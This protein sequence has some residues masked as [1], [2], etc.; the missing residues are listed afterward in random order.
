MRGQFLRDVART[1]TKPI[2]RIDLL[3]LDVTF[4]GARSPRLGVGVAS[5]DY[6]PF[7]AAQQA[8]QAAGGYPDHPAAYTLIVVAFAPGSMRN[9]EGKMAAREIFQHVNTDTFLNIGLIED[10]KLPAGTIRVSVLLG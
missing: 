1:V 5:G 3:D 7:R 10:E 4:R 9:G 6:R 2:V 8:F